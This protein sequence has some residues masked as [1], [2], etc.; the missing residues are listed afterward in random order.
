MR[1]AET[2]VREAREP[3]TGA[4]A[5]QIVTAVYRGLLGREPDEG[6][7]AAYVTHMKGGMPL[8][9]LL[10][11]IT[12]SP[13][14]RERITEDMVQIA[15]R[16]NDSYI[17]SRPG[18]GKR[19]SISKTRDLKD[20]KS[21]EILVLQSCDP[22]HYYDMLVD[23][24]RTVRRFCQT[25]DFSYE[26]FIG[27]KRGY[28]SWHS[29]YNRIVIL[30]ELLDSDFTGWV[31]YLDADAYIADPNFDLH[32]YLSNKSKYAAI[33]AHT[34]MKDIW[35]DVNIGIFMINFGSEATR[36][37]INN[38]YKYFNEISEED[39]RKSSEWGDVPSDQDLLHRVLRD[40]PEYR[41]SIYLESPDLLNGRTGGFVQQF[42][43]DEANGIA[44]RKQ[45]LKKKVD[46]LLGIADGAAAMS[47]INPIQAAVIVTVLYKYLLAKIVDKD[48][49]DFYV[50]QICEGGLEYGFPQV[51]KAVVES[52]EFRAR[53]LSSTSPEL[54]TYQAQ[55]VGAAL[56]RSILGREPDWN[57]RANIPAVLRER[58]LEIGL[59]EV[60]E[61]MLD[62][63][64]F[65]VRYRRINQVQLRQ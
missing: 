11:A 62:C 45:F 40:H 5:E 2:E 8:E 30:K 46:E 26:C 28:F 15:E 7:F 42:T 54:D 36:N 17:S 61:E 52:E 56:Y 49:M 35:H 23:T 25:H 32:T 31:F 44:E 41:P 50:S 16:P 24:S 14:F 64:E 65:R 43:R 3:L 9:H 18:T 4:F 29:V 13:E 33:F 53:Y 22:Y 1:L 34:R 21:P 12:A 47:G 48:T 19:Q 58:G 55:I 51:L 63:H 37:L 39:L 59:Q 60:L 10:S 38:W 20:Q 6:G 27:I 57:G